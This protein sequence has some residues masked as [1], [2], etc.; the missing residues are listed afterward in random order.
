MS[1]DSL[2]MAELTECS[3]V[4]YVFMPARATSYAAPPPPPERGVA[5]AVAARYCSKSGLA[6]QS[7]SICLR[8]AGTSELMPRSTA[9]YLVKSGP[10]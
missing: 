10:V 8:S 1:F 4:V 7:S 9:L 5:A 2:T 6:Q 3:D